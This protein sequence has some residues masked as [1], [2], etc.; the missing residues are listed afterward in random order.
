DLA[1]DHP[2][3]ALVAER[4]E[5][6]RLLDVIGAVAV[7]ALHPVI[8]G[9]PRFAETVHPVPH[10]AVLVVDRDPDVAGDVGA[11]AAAHRA[12]ELLRPDLRERHDKVVGAHIGLVVVERT[13]PYIPIAVIGDV[14]L[15]DRRLA[16]DERAL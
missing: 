4:T 9:Q 12:A 5:L 15:Q 14:D 7:A 11:I 1:V 6:A 2:V 13:D 16:A 8:L 3:V 10:H